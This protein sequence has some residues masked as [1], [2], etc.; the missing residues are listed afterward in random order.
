VLRARWLQYVNRGIS[1]GNKKAT[2]ALCSLR[3]EHQRLFRLFLVVGRRIS[4]SP[5]FVLQTINP[6]EKATVTLCSE[7]QSISGSFNLQ[8]TFQR[9][10]AFPP[11]P[12]GTGHSLPGH[13]EEGKG[14]AGVFHQNNATRN[15]HALASA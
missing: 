11:T 1:R 8:L 5:S 14:F 6:T 9:S 4:V 13:T 15:P 10:L 12:A 2:V 3:T 7:T